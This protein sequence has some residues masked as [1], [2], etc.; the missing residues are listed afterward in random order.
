[1]SYENKDPITKHL[2]FH[3]FLLTKITQFIEY[4]IN[5]TWNQTLYILSLSKDEWES[6]T[7]GWCCLHCRKADLPNVVR[8][9]EAKDGLGLAGCH[10]LAYA[11][12]LA[13]KVGLCAV[14]SLIYKIISSNG[15]V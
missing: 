6:G 7:E 9:L 10:M 8:I 1:M 3:T 2:H 11:K 13:I 15:Y 4:L 5:G 12:D 14:V